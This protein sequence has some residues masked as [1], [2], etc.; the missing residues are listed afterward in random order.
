MKLIGQRGE[1]RNSTDL[2]I[3]KELFL[4]TKL[5]SSSKQFFIILII[6]H[7]FSRVGWLFCPWDICGSIYL[8]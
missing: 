4:V 3:L 1:K 6:S 8:K 7:D 2:K 5:F